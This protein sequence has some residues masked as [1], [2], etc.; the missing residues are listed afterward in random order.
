MLGRINA[1]YGQGK[2]R[3]ALV[4]DGAAVAGV[5]ALCRTRWLPGT[6]CAGD[7][8]WVNQVVEQGH[9]SRRDRGKHA[10][11]KRVEPIFYPQARVLAFS[12]GRLLLC[13]HSRIGD[14]DYRPHKQVKRHGFCGFRAAHDA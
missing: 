11:G 1:V 14:V 8:T 13:L 6:T 5:H 10:S 12:A 2:E 9:T 3:E 7:W 4:N